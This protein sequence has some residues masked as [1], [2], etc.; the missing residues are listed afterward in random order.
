MPLERTYLGLISDISG[1]TTLTTMTL[2]EI[3]ESDFAA[4]DL[5]SNLELYLRLSNEEEEL[6][7]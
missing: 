2:G 3:T 4:R 5:F 6:A 1:V 7:N